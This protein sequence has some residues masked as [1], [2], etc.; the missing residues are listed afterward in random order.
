[1]IITEEQIGD[2]MASMQLA[3]DDTLAWARAQ[4]YIA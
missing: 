1:M 2:L 3:L 4:G